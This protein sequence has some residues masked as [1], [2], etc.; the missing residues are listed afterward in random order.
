MKRLWSDYGLG[1]VLAS[2]WLGFWAAYAVTEWVVST[3]YEPHSAP[4]WLEWLNGTFENNQSEFLQLASMVAFTAA[5][6]FRG[7]PESKRDNDED[8]AMLR[9]TLGRL[10][11]ANI[12]H[13]WEDRA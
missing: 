13:G 3:R 2:L 4:W 1:I 6:S 8:K 11:R 7:S 9:E 5:L 10:R 12:G